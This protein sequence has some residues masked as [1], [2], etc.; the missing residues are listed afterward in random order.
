MDKGG[1]NM[2]TI[3]IISFALN[4]LFVS[5]GLV[6]VFTLR[7]KRRLSQAEAEAKEIVN[8]EKISEVMNNYIVKPLKSEINALRKDVRALQ[9]AIA[10]ISNCPHSDD[11]PVRRELQNHENGERDQR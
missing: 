3:E 9:R 6:T 7:S 11:C 5:G 1:R 4:I 8:D 10:Q 2:N